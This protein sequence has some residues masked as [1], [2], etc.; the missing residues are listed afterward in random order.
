[1][2]RNIILI[3]LAISLIGGCAT[4]CLLEKSGWIVSWG[5]GS[6]LGISPF[7]FFQITRPLYYGKSGAINSVLLW[8]ILIVKF[9]VTTLVILFLSNLEFIVYTPFIISFIVM[10][11]IIIAIVLVNHITNKQVSYGK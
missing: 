10:A 7:A 1:M 5:I 6:L 9:I 4:L 3:S 2:N 8:A 11:P